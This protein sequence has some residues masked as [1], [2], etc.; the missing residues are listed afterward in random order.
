LLYIRSIHSEN[1]LVHLLHQPLI[2]HLYLHI[3]E[4]SAA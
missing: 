3:S 1:I 4:D 2:T